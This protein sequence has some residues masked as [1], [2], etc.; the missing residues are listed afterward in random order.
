MDNWQN[1]KGVANDYHHWYNS[2][3]EQENKTYYRVAMW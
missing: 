3:V 1:G 2:L